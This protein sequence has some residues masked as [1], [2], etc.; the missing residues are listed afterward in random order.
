MVSE[1][2]PFITENEMLSLKY[3]LLDGTFSMFTWL[4]IC[5]I[6][7]FYFAILISKYV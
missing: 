3:S 7:N 1:L 6:D 2:M 4:L 5:D